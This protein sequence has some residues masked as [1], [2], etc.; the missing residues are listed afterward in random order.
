MMDRHIENLV[1]VAALMALAFFA[2][3]AL[4][5]RQDIPFTEIQWAEGDC[6]AKGGLQSV[7]WYSATCGHGEQ[8]PL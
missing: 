7:D 3:F 4:G 8:V 6:A 2:G 5:K 1:M